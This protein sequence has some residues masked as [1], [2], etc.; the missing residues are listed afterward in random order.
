MLERLSEGAGP[1]GRVAPRHPLRPPGRARCIQQERGLPGV[2]VEGAGVCR[3]VRKWIAFANDAAGAR[4]ADAVV[5]LLLGEPP[6]QRHEDG[7]RPLRSPVEEG[8][9]EPVVHHHGKP[10]AGRQVEPTRDPGHARQ[11]RVVADPGKGLELGVT[12]AGR[13]ERLREVHRP[14]SRAR[15]RVSR[16]SS[17]AAT[18]GA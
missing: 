4:I 7:A 1:V 15:A 16:A 5:E 11:Q 9:L 17:I 12:L 6:G 2:S 8:R 10:V 18:I 3:P 14:A 13:E